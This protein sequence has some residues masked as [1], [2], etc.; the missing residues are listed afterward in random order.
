MLKRFKLTTD[1]KRYEVVC[2]YPEQGWRHSIR[3]DLGV[4]IWHR[5]G[6]NNSIWVDAVQLEEGKAATA[7]VP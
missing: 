3:P 5:R 2:H 6:V 7:Y 4:V 1:W